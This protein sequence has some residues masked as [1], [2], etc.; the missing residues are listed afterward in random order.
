MNSIIDVAYQFFVEKLPYVTIVMFSIGILLNIRRWYYKP[1]EKNGKQRFFTASAL[2]YVVLDVVFFRKVYKTCKLTWLMLIIFHFGAAGIIFGHLRG[3]KVWS[4]SMF[5]PFGEAAVTFIVE[6]LPVYMG[7]L[8]IFS[9]LI[10]LGRRILLEGKQLE[11]MSN[12][13]VALVL[14]LITSIL[15]QGMRIIAPESA[16]DGVHEITFIPNLIV[17]HLEKYPSFHW[18]Y[19]HILFTQLFIAYIPFSKLVH[20]YTGVISSALYGSRRRR[21]GI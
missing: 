8:F 21:Y 11:S 10:L 12:D 4:V 16:A 3:F 2:K 14:L 15:G 19:L 5:T 1:K 17:L 7:Y 6:V 13:Y 18:F 20:I 9:I